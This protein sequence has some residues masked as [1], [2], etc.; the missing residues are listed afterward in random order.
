MLPLKD[1]NGAPSGLVEG[2]GATCGAGCCLDKELQ[3]PT[4]RPRGLLAGVGCGLDRARGVMEA[5]GWEGQ[6]VLP[7]AGE[8]TLG[9]PCLSSALGGKQWEGNMWQ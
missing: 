3:A 4:P 6:G 9:E 5:S 2:L 1:E 8:V 7:A